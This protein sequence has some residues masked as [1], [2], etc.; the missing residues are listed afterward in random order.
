MS[1]QTFATHRYKAQVGKILNSAHLQ[2]EPHAL[3]DCRI[4]SQFSY[5]MKIV[6]HKIATGT[7]TIAGADFDFDGIE[8]W[9][10]CSE[11]LTQPFNRDWVLLQTLEANQEL[12]DETPCVRTT[13]HFQFEKLAK[14][15][16]EVEA[17]AS[18]C[19]CFLLHSVRWYTSKNTPMI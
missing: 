3:G 6:I 7:A 19:L 2:H 10:D 13:Q 4:L 14:K 8:G 16:D 1:G 12:L 9:S 11:E 15:V 17:A 5:P 18:R